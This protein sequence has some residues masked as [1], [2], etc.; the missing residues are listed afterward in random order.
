MEKR[1]IA[2]D[3]DMMHTSAR[4]MQN[5]LDKMKAEIENLF[6]EIEEFTS[7]WDGDV[8]KDFLKQL[9]Q[10]RQKIQEFENAAEKLTECMQYAEKEYQ[11]CEGAVSSIIHTIQI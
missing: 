11:S 6:L 1:K 7:M 5:T 3:T 2:V 9:R 10:D 4:E 8:H